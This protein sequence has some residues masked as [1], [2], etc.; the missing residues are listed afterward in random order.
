MRW[1]VIR[2]SSLQ[3]TPWRNGHGTSRNI[4][5]R[6]DRGG[7]L[8]WQ[9]GIA[10][11]T[12]EAPFSHYPNCDRIFTP[13]EGEEPPELAFDDGPFEPCELLVPKS[14]KGE[15]PTRV[16]VR[17]PGRAFNTIADRRHYTVE[18]SVFQLEAGDPVETPDA[19]EVVIHCL[20]GELSTAGDLIEPG[21]SLLGPGPA[22]PAAA[23]KNATVIIAA[24]RPVPA[25]KP[26][27]PP[28]AA[29]PG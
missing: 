29:R 1:T 23:A 2:G 21:D 7:T 25:G 18:V 22:A 12:G 6:L 26:G 20:T 4:V 19:P 10:E 11:L 16:R 27:D 17:A 9:V 14:F 13:I 28:G 3:T 15:W 24:I 8:L 5:T